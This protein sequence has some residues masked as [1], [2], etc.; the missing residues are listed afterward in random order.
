MMKHFVI[1]LVIA[2]CLVISSSN[3]FAQKKIL[4]SQVLA[5]NGISGTIDYF[6]NQTDRP[7]YQFL[8]GGLEALSA[9]EYILQVRY[10]N[11]SGQLP[12][13]PAGRAEIEYNPDAVFDP[14]FIEIALKGALERLE[15]AEKILDEMS[16]ERFLLELYISDI[17][18]DINKNGKRGATEGLLQQL[19][20]LP[21]FQNSKLKSTLIR[22]DIAD[23]DWLAAYVHLLS[24]MAEMVLAVDPTPAIKTISKGRALME[25]KGVLRRD[26]FLGEDATIDSITV[27]IKALDGVPDKN[28]TRKALAHF[29]SMITHNQDFWRL[30]MQ[31]TDD[32]AE[33]LPNP[34]Q[35]SAFGVAV[36]L[37]TAE[38][39]QAVLDEISDVLEGKA[40]IPHWRVGA[41]RGEEFGVGINFAKLMNDPSE[42]DV[43]LMLH[44]AAIAPYLESGKIANMRVWQDFS[45]LTGGQGLLFSLWFN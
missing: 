32:E 24:G 26:P 34:N 14:A 18:F 38:A 4:V 23:A 5:K 6:K 12:L 20:E 11:Y 30:I 3:A 25:E 8:L 45:R 2:F 17:W 44:G 40:L 41:G 9:I 37:E 15:R 28:R 1:R 29:K 33:W 21:A 16:D 27:L 10:E 43:I 31:E 7:K 22:F 42:F 35:K 19:G 39:W 13:V 36:D